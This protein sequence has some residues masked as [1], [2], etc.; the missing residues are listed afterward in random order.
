VKLRIGLRNWQF[1]EVLDGL[2]DGDRLALPD[3]GVAVGV[4][5]IP[6][7]PGPGR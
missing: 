3:E 5:V 1:V 6:R 7:D 2:A 4:V